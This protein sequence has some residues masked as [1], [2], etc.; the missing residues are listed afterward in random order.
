MGTSFHDPLPK[1][2]GKRSL[3]ANAISLSGFV[4]VVFVL[5]LIGAES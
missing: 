2:S 4:A 3:G 5:L 1:N